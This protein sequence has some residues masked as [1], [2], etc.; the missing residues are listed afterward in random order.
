DDFGTGYSSLTYLN[1]LPVE[2]LKID[3]ETLKIDQIGRAH[4]LNACRLRP[5]RLIRALCAACWMTPTI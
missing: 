3:L 5:S 4:R 2:T 1:R